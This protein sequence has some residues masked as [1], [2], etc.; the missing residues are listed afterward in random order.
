MGGEGDG[1]EVE[2]GLEV[3]R[4]D[5]GG[6]EGGHGERIIQWLNWREVNIP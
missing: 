2:G 6:G 1:V 5:Q 4:D 3:A